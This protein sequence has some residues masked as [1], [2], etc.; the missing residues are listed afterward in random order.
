VRQNAILAGRYL[1][2]R[3]AGAGGMG[4]VWRA[5]D[6]ETGKPVALK[7]LPAHDPGDAT[8]FAREAQILAGLEHPHIIRYGAHGAD[9]DGAPFL[10]ME[11]LEGEDLS[12]RLARGG[13]S[14]EESVTLALRVTDA[15]AF[16]HARDVVHRD[17]KPSNLFLPGGR[18]DSVKVLDFGIARGAIDARHAHW[19]AHRH[20]GIHDARASARR[21]A[22]R[23]A[24][25]VFSLGCVLFECLTGEPAFDGEHAAAILTKVLFQE[26]PSARSLKP[27]VPE[28]LDALVRR[29]LA[30][31][32]DERPADGQAAAAALA[33]LGKMSS[34]TANESAR[35]PSLTG[36]EQRAVAVILVGAPEGAEPASFN[37][38]PTIDMSADEALLCE[39]ARHSGAGERLLDGSVVVLVAGTAA[40]TDLCAQAASCALALRDP[41]SGRRITLAM[42]RGERTGRSLGPAIDRAAQLSGAAASRSPS[43]PSSSSSSSARGPHRRDRRGA[44]RRPLRGA[45]SRGLLHEVGARLPPSERRRVAEFLGEIVGA[46]FPDEGS[47]PLRAARRDAQGIAE[48]LRAA[49]L[50][51]VRAACAERPLIVLL[52]D[53]HWGDRPTVTLLDAA[54]RDPDDCPLFVLALARPE[55]REVFPNLWKD[56]QLCELR[57]HELGRRAGE[58]LARHVLGQSADAEAIARIVCL[59]EGN[60]FYLEELIRWTAEG[61]GPH[62][63]ETVVAMVESRL[64]AQSD[65]ARRLLRAASV[66]GEVFW[67]GGVAALVDGEARRI[68]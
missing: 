41:A 5:L 31:P 47:L 53:L 57:L 40:A 1:L 32:R 55:V 34:G 43:S 61:K 44:A 23:R 21:A 49:F 33:A 46:P 2:E 13:L 22:R 17:L 3:R 30:K 50:D 63:P 35:V 51:F 10:T 20:A 52:E 58:R 66:F 26:T 62:V 42:G 19:H 14:V 4:E 38:A 64:S 54:L 59:S 6:R 37:S 68:E 24:R 67:V 16:A 28:A 60:A 25:G 12:A 36:S 18:I 29:M 11:W 27:D 8:R 9:A 15:L 65:E 56:R 7:R 45:R 39:A 48:Q